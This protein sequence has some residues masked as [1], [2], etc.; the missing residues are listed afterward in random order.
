M[1]AQG[2]EGG[3]TTVQQAGQWLWKLQ[4]GCGFLGNRS[5]RPV[6]DVGVLSAGPE[7]HYHLPLKQGTA[8]DDDTNLF[9]WQRP[10]PS[11]PG[12]CCSWELPRRRGVECGCQD[13]VEEEAQPGPGVQSHLLLRSQMPTSAGP[14]PSRME[15]L[16]TPWATSQRTVVPGLSVSTSS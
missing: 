12:P 16:L 5:L 14:S 13:E 10:P 2:G 4:G 11:R 8:R 15:P 1:F 6:G 7:D 3:D 9:S